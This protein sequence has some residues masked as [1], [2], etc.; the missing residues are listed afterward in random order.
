MTGETGVDPALAAAAPGAGPNPLTA[1]ER[2]AL[3][4]SMDEAAVADIA[5]MLHLSESTVRNRLSSAIAQQ[6]RKP[7]MEAVPAARQQGRL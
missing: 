4:A 2:D 5:E 1:G 7:W 3:D 6:A